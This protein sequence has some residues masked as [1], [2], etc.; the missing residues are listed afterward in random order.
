MLSFR[1]AVSCG[2]GALATLA[3]STGTASA[4]PILDYQVTTAGC[5]N[6]TTTGS[7]TDVASYSG[8]TFDGLTMSNGVTDAFGN[9]TV[10]LGTLARDTQNYSQSLIGSDFVLQVSFLLPLGIGSDT[11]E[12][13]AT[14]FGTQGQP[15]DLDFNNTF[16]K[17][18]FTNQSGTGSFEFRV[19]DILSLNKNHSATLTGNIQ[20]AVFTPTVAGDDSADPMPI[21]EPA[22]VLLLGSGLVVVARRFRRRASK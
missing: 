19:N 5:F 20:S 22:S 8:Y 3:L 17:Y 21:P 16:T 10:S 12:F 14:I 4:T 2:V 15:G 6:C 7:F 11:D 18:T 9:A 1:R 13:V